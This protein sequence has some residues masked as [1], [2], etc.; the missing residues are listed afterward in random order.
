MKEA[1]VEKLKI[2]IFDNRREL[3]AAA[4]KAV[5]DAIFMVSK[6][7][8]FVNIIF[9]AAA[10]QNE[11]LDVLAED[12]SIDW[13][14][15]NAFHMDE[16]I[17]L[18]KS[19]PQKF[20]NYL[21]KKLFD[22]VPMHDVYL[23]NENGGDPDVEAARYSALLMGNKPDITCMGIGENTHLAFNDPHVAEFNDPL[24]VK[25]VDIDEPCKQQQVNEGC[26]PA[27]SDVPSFAYT[28]TIP[29]LLQADYIFCMVPGR[30]KAN[31]IV[32]TLREERSELYPSTVLRGHS[33]AVLYLDGES[34][35]EYLKEEKA[36]SVS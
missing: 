35:G 4:A 6:E 9:A 29:V 31:A 10:S 22:R 2:Q 36:I 1:I 16:Y 5:A 19:H 33:N 27:V 15:V 23:L 8:E 11:F 17:G 14:R 25:V 3:G 7:K 26:F 30:S 13:S 18:D 24:M 28:L 34:A 20:S 32:H 21:K 12:K